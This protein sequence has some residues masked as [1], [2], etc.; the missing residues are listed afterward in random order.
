MKKIN[1]QNVVKKWK[2]FL[3]LLIS[4]SSTRTLN[5]VGTYLHDKASTGFIIQNR[6]QNVVKF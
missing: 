6:V 2:I 5:C 1:Y 4:N 3:L